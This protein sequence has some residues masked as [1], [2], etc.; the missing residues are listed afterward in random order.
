MICKLFDTLNSIFHSVMKSKIS[1]K[2]LDGIWL[3]TSKMILYYDDVNGIGIQE[4]R[5]WSYKITRKW[6][7][8]DHNIDHGK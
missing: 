8:P 3:A 2:K 7:L 4:Q 6:V 1:A 5:P